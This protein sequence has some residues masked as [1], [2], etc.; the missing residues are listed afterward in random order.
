MTNVFRRASSGAALAGAALLAG[1]ASLPASGPTA[2]EITRA[3]A[4]DRNTIGMRI[5]DINADVVARTTALDEAATAQLPTLAVLARAG[6]N[7]TVGPGDQLDIAIFEVGASLFTPARGTADG[8]DPSAQAQRFPAVTVDRSG[9]IRLPYAGTLDV[10]GRTPDEIAGL[11]ERAYRGKSQSL[12][13]IVSVRSNLSDTVFVSG[14]LKKPGRLD[15][16]L[17]NERLLDAIAAAG[18][19]VAPTPDI[20]VRFSR[21]GR[22]VEER[23]DRIRAGAPDD[24]VL[25]PGDR[26][27][28]VRS[29]RSF[30]I[31]GAANRPAQLAFDQ[32]DLT[33][34]EA[35]AR[36]GGPNDG[37]ANPRGVFL[38]RYAQPDAAPSNAAQS[39]AHEQLQPT[40]YRLDMLDPASYFLAQHFAMRDK[41]VLYVSNAGINRTAK[42]VSIINQLFSPFVA[43]RTLSNR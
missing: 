9:Q 24:L 37:G 14:D 20:V 19:A 41:D 10:A 43:A 18:G 6:R 15:L 5:V 17:Q 25:V 4:P 39:T 22:L 8:F 13:V 35:V 3:T 31:L 21:D 30:V 27:E 29:P 23:L 11:I 36:A 40:I 2:G 34:A 26:I 28:L 16:S 7:D 32:S 38:F 42:F 1:C 12:Q 33:L